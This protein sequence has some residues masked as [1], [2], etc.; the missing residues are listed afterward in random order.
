MM[1]KKKIIKKKK[2]NPYLTKQVRYVD[3]KN[4]ELLEKFISSHGKILPGRVTGLNALQQRAMTQA[5]KRA[6][7]MALL[8][9]VKE[10]VR[11]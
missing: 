6:R 7:H 1:R 11:K 4:V 10:R 8:P 2:S 9:F 3:Y 5:I